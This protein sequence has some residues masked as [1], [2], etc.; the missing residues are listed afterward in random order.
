[1]WASQF[2]RCHSHA[3]EKWTPLEQ[4]PSQARSIIHC[5]AKDSILERIDDGMNILRNFVNI[6]CNV[7]WFVAPMRFWFCIWTIC[8]VLMM[9]YIFTYSPTE[10]QSVAKISHELA[11]VASR[12]IPQEVGRLQVIVSSR[13]EI[14]FIGR[15]SE[16][17]LA[18]CLRP[19]SETPSGH[20]C[21]CCC[22]WRAHEHI[23]DPPPAHI[24][25]KKSTL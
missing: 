8:T 9:L 11:V 22:F 25:R 19:Y 13:S 7:V 12:S 23:A 1:M 14:F 5:L 3:C 20:F 10:S 18:D 2:K 6:H 17:K 4:R 21:N 24:I 15:Y 16:S